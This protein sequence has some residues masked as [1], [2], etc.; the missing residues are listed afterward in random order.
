MNLTDLTQ[1]SLWTALAA[2]T[3]EASRRGLRVRRR[4]LVG[5]CP[6]AALGEFRAGGLALPGFDDA[7]VLERA[8]GI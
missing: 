8:L 6:E 4:E 1:T 5:L 2:V 7:C 3:A